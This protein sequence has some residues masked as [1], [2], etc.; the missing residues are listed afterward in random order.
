MTTSNQLKATLRPLFF[1]TIV[2]ASCLSGY[3]A[4]ALDAINPTYS[5]NGFGTLGAVHSD[6]DQADFVSSWLLQPNGAGHTSEWHAGVDTKIGG[7]L[8]IQFNSA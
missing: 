2:T 6:E 5:F 8:D 7:Q 1:G 3:Q 4:A